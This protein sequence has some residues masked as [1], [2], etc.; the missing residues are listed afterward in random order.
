MFRPARQRYLKAGQP[1]EHEH[2]RE[3]QTKVSLLSKI[4]AV[5]PVVLLVHQSRFLFW[6]SRL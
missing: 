1:A 6:L 4:N 3:Y 5:A 2:H